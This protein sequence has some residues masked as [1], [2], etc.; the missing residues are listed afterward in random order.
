V[1]VTSTPI[2]ARTETSLTVRASDEVRV[3]A[4]PGARDPIRVLAPR[5][6]FGSPLALLV[7]GRRAGWYQVLL[8]G[9]PNGAIGW[10]RSTDVAPREVVHEV[11]VD[12][13][14]RTLRVL[15]R[16]EVV[17]SSSAAIGDA[18]HPTPTGRFSLTDKLATGQPDGPY[19]PYA[20]GISGRSDVLTEF[21]GGDGQIGIHGTDDPTSIGRAVSHGCVR[22]PNDV[23]TALSNLLPLGTPVVIT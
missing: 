16:G 17:L 11:R 14:T 12:L 6:G 22:V 4:R 21:R 5:T 13:A 8:P 19:G 20:L 9:R 23:A 3:Y 1:V 15:E 10:A 7:V 2:P 18:A